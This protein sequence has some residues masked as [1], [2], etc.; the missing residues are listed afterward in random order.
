[1]R[2][3]RGTQP[4]EDPEAAKAAEAARRGAM[5]ADVVP[6]TATRIAKLPPGARRALARA[7]GSDAFEAAFRLAAADVP[8]GEEARDPDGW[9]K[10]VECIAVLTPGPVRG[11]RRTAHAGETPAGTGLHEAR[12]SAR[13]LGGLLSSAGRETRREQALRLCRRVRQIRRGPKIRAGFDLT[14]LAGWILH[15]DDAS[16]RQIAEG[17]R[18]RE[19]AMERTGKETK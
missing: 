18:R 4:D 16:R 11:R 3:E 9:R 14:P 10:L 1:M 19:R 12:T 7:H 15:G 2:K 5:L 13:R 8:H 17:W 6:K